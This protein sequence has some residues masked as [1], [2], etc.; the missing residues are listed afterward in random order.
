[1]N[2]QDQHY[3]VMFALMYDFLSILFISPL[4]QQW[5][6]TSRSFICSLSSYICLS[7]H[8]LGNV[9]C[10]RHDRKTKKFD[11]N[12][13]GRSVDRSVEYIV[14]RRLCVRYVRNLIHEGHVQMVRHTQENS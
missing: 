12:A 2:G 5:P 6:K 4:W 10:R 13:V 8:R 14:A 9:V 11:V 7:D 1:M 3:R